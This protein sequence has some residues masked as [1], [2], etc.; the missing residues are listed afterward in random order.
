MS[1]QTIQEASRI[2]SAV[3]DHSI[4][5]AG[6]VQGAIRAGDFE[7]VGRLDAAQDALLHCRIRLLNGEVS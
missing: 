6:L 2:R 3:R 5:I 7:R 1:V 4:Y